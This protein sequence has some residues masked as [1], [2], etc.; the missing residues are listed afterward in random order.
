[1]R[2]KGEKEKMKEKKEKKKEE[3]EDDTV[4]FASGCGF[5]ARFL[6]NSLATVGAYR[7]LEILRL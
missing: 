1:M 6:F 2:V 5:G 7:R 4:S 3:A